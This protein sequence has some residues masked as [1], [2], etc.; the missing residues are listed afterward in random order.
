MAVLL[1]ENAGD[2][3]LCC[4]ATASIRF[5]SGMTS[6]LA[7]LPG[8]SLTRNRANFNDLPTNKP[9]S[10]VAN[11]QR[12]GVHADPDLQRLHQLRAEQ[13]GR[14]QSGYREAGSTLQTFIQGNVTREKI[15]KTDDFTQAKERYLSMNETEKE[16]LAGNFI[17][18]LIH[19]TKPEIQK[20]AIE[21]LA[22]VDEG[23]AA[24]VAKG[25]GL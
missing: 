8:L 11:N 19:V 22:Q 24:N 7:S 16:H 1:I 2:L 25:L 3:K 18:D 10:P 6:I 9:L 5:L 21:N 14:T 13:P 17:A 23:L 12:N 15:Y 20:R 4:L